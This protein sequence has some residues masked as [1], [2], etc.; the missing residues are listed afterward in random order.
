[1]ARRPRVRRCSPTGSGRR[2][3]NSDPTVIGKKDP[4]RSAHR[5][6]GR[7]ARALGAVSGRHRDHRERGDQPAHL[8]AMMV[9]NR[10]HR[11][12]ELFGRLAGRLNR[13]G[14]RRAE[15]GARRHG[16]GAPRGILAQGAC[17][18]PRNDAAQPDRGAGRAP[19]LILLLAAAGRRL[20][21][22]LLERREADP[23]PLGAPRGRARR[24]R[25]AGRGTGALR[26]TLLRR[27]PG[28]VRRRRRWWVC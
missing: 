14:A 5:D 16:Q 27:E 11:M 25:R 2:R 4:S 26:R 23:R 13:T 7:C 12:T 9:T 8:G 28:P 15:S 17:A 1:M 20:R 19:V 18:A 3:S 6:R 10:M 22:R 24:A 21:D